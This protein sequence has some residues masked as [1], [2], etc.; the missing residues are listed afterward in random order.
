MPKG[1]RQPIKPWEF[2]EHKRKAKKMLKLFSQNNSPLNPVVNKRQ[3][4]KTQKNANKKLNKKRNGHSKK[5]SK[6]LVWQKGASRLI[7]NNRFPPKNRLRG[8][9][10]L[11]KKSKDNRNN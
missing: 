3:N 8:R 1:R 7:E 9:V 4:K 6:K 2:N 10:A 5:N 11:K